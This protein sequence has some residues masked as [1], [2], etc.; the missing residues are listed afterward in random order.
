MGGGGERGGDRKEQ[1]LSEIECLDRAQSCTDV[2]L[3]PAH[4]SIHGVCQASPLCSRLWF[5]RR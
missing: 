1:N 3:E 4:S 2:Y 5:D